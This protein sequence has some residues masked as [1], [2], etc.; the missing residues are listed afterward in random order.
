MPLTFGQRLVEERDRLSLTQ[1]DVAE[2]TRIHRKTQSAYEK[3]ESYPDA[4]YLMTLFAHGFDVTY[5]LTGHRAPRYGAVDPEL[6]QRVFRALEDGL[7]HA[8]R[9]FG[10]EKK[11]K[12]LSLVYQAASESGQVD[13]LVVQKA[14][15][16]LS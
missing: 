5:L 6:L 2:W 7:A 16:L 10:G 12:L 11:A 9:S 14:V 15:D 1:T 4:A 8:G 13:P 3:E